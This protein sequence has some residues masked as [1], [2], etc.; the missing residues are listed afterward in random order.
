MTNEQLFEDLRQFIAATVTQQT[1]DV[2]GDIAEVKSDVSSMKD[3]ITGIKSDLARLERKVDDGFA[4]ASA[5]VETTNTRVD[6]LEDKADKVDV[7]L[8]RLEHRVA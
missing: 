6:D 5:V 8:K 4:G 2:R 7:R 1:S 3:D